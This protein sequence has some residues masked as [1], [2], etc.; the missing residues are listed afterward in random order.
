MNQRRAREQSLDARSVLEKPGS[1]LAIPGGVRSDI[2]VIARVTQQSTR[3]RIGSLAIDAADRA[4]R[5][6]IH[7][8]R[9]T[10]LPKF[11][12]LRSPIKPRG[13]LSIPTTMDSRYLSF[14]ST[15]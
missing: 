2:S 1:L 13:A 5:T 8:S 9:T 6:K 3:A 15:T 14:P 11:S 4:D 12:P 10:C 7:A